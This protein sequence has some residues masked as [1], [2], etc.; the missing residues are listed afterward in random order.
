MLPADLDNALSRCIFEQPIRRE[1]EKTSADR[2][3]ELNGPS[4][5]RANEWF[6]LLSATEIDM[7]G[8]ARLRSI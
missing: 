3:T 2:M 6:T 4:V 1:E 7:S 5:T 8:C